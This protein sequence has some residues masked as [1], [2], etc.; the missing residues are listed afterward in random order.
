MKK[1]MYLPVILALIMLAAIAGSANY[2]DNMVN[3]STHKNTTQNA[4]Y[5]IPQEILA[6]NGTAPD[7]SPSEGP[8]NNTTSN[9]MASN[10]TNLKL[11]MADNQSFALVPIGKNAK[12]A[13]EVAASYAQF[14]AK[15][16][17]PI[18]LGISA[19]NGTKFGRPVL[20][21]RDT[22]RIVFVC[23]IV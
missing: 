18:G 13:S 3:S 21:V 23:D 16:E 15:P 5:P 19:K 2:V 20:P 14:F 9:S 12:T 4:S 6:L 10:Q 17:G 22:E 1:P 11:S 7:L 8:S